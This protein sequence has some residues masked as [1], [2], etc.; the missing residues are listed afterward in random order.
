MYEDDA[1]FAFYT[2]ANLYVGLMGAYGEI[3]P[4]FS[5][6]LSP[7]LVVYPGDSPLFLSLGLTGDITVSPIDG[8]Y[9][10][11]FLGLQFGFGIGGVGD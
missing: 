11:G 10:Q 9:V 6:V 3:G 4:G 7:A 2:R 5:A 8:G 1:P